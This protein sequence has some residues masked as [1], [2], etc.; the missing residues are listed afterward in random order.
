MKKARAVRQ[1]S[2]SAL[3]D[4]W[5]RDATSAAIV[6]MRGVVQVDGPIPPGTPIGKLTDIEL[7]WLF[8]ASLF[9][10][11][12][13]RAQQATAE[14]LDTEQL[15]RLTALDPDPWDAGAV[16]AILPELADTCAEIVDWSQPLAQWPRDNIVA[17]LLKAMPLIRKAVI[18]RDLS[19]KG[20]TRKSSADMI[21]RQANAAAGGPLMT[22][23]EFNDP[24]GI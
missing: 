8:S 18:A 15:I 9:A 16:E 23:D 22:S 17:F 14:Q 20:V 5:Q 21:A 1:V 3:E 12:G 2:L 6:A 4:Q 13:K 10:W 7:G 11:I 24:I 19:A